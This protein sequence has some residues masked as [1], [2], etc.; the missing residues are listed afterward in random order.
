M[1]K[2]EEKNKHEKRTRPEYAKFNL[3]SV[4]NSVAKLNQSGIKD[5]THRLV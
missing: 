4:L 3:I 5:L 1:T 2:E